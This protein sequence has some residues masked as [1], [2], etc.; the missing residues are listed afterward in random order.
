MWCTRVPRLSNISAG[1]IINLGSIIGSLGNSGQAVYAAT[2]SGLVGKQLEYL[3][4]HN[5]I[6][7]I[8]FTK[9]LASEYGSRGITANVVAPGFVDTDMTEG[10]YI[11]Y[12]WALRLIAILNYLDLKAAE[13]ILAH[14][15]LQRFG[16]PEVSPPFSFHPASRSID[17]GEYHYS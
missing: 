4:Y 17:D 15:P 5:D 13:D 16:K 10:G 12:R 7:C 6:W 3:Q 1:C 11:S 2:K 8:G 14:I 9:S